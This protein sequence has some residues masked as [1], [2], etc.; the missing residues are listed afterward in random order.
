MMQRREFLAA[1]AAAALTAVAGSKA[2]AAEEKAKQL[3]ELRIYH[4]ASEEKLKAY[5]EFLAKVAI[6]AY[7]RAGIQPVGVFKLLEAD[8]AKLKTV[9]EDTLALRVLLPHKNAESVVALPAKLAANQAYQDA[10]KDILDAPRKDPAYT[11]FESSLLLG[12]D[13]CPQVE[14][15]SKAATRVLQLR[16]YQGHSDLRHRVKV[17]MFNEGGEVAIFRDCGMNPVFFGQELIGSNLPNLTYMVGFDD[18]KAMGA[19]WGKFIKDPR[20]DALKKD[21]RFDESEPKTIINLVLRPG[22]GSQI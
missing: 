3:L 13:A 1:S 16:I 9:K 2:S 15:P 5:D 18:E 14:V 20:W 6:P 22:A 4:F 8:N 17:A 21:P 7:N 12:F 10:G 19:G 11:S